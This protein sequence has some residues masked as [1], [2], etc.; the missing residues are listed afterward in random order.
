MKRPDLKTIAKELNLRARHHQIG[1]LQEI[2]AKLKGL[3]RRPGHDIFSSQTTFDQWAFH[4]GGASELQFNIALE[5]HDRRLRHGV[6]FSLKRRQSLQ[7]PIGVLGPKIRLFNKFMRQYP[8]YF[9]DLRMW[10][11]QPDRSPNYMPGPIPLKLV[12]EGVFVFLG[13]VQPIDRVDFEVV[14]GDFDKLLFL[15]NFVESRGESKPVTLAESEKGFVFRAGFH[16]K[17]SS[18]MATQVQKQREI[19]LLQNK[20]QQ[21]LCQ[22]LA[23]QFGPKNVSAENRSDIG[24]SVDVVLRRR[25]AY[26]FYE[27][28]TAD[29]PRACIREAIGQLLEYAFWRGDRAVR[30]LIVVGKTALDKDGA[31]YLLLLKNKFSLPIEYE[32]IAV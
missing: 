26:W 32:Q 16:E 24:T 27:I 13:Q 1:R 30:R 22:R 14:L 31:E 10:H 3:S 17:A 2:R 21:A 20:M 5:A 7:D 28:K 23:A 25:K 8:K 29:S 4:H 18:A 6:A 15:Y 9:A 19:I 12:T 11:Y